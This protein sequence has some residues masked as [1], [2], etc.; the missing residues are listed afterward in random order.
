[1][2]GPG[3]DAADA[4][5]RA[6]PVVDD[7]C[8]LAEAA[9]PVLP[10]PAAEVVAVEVGLLRSAFTGLTRDVGAMLA[11]GGDPELLRAT[12]ARWVDGVGAPVSRLVG[13]ADD[14]ALEADDRWTG[15]AADAYRA[16]L[17]AQRAALTAVLAACREVD[18]ALNDLAAAITTFWTAAGA[19]CATML[20]GLAAALASGST[21]VGAAAAVACAGVVVGAANSVL[22]QLTVLRNA[23][24][25]ERAALA[26]RVADDTAFP[27]GAWP[28]STAVGAGDWT[29]R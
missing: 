22:H 29:P 14:D 7:L 8:R 13:L 1:M 5:G 10:A 9:L 18:A 27:L 3:A 4:L 15:R 23:T 28:R 11:V 19:A 12:A 21:G 17:P 26:R 20:L 2:S 16:I 24:A 6:G 25:A